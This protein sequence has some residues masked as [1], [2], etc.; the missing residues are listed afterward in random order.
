MVRRWLEE[1]LIGTFVNGLKLKLAKEL[2]LKKP[3]RLQETMRMVEMFDQSYYEEKSQGKC[4][5]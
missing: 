5:E 3:R 4:G 1:A 2:K